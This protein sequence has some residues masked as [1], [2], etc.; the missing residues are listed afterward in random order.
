M[1][2]V[3]DVFVKEANVRKGVKTFIS[4]T[5]LEKIKKLSRRAM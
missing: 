4:L 2:M 3:K 1:K 5:Y